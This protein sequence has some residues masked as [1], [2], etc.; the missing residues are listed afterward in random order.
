MELVW[1]AG[2]NIENKFIYSILSSS[3]HFNKS[4]DADN[5]DNMAITMILYCNYSP[6]RQGFLLARKVPNIYISLTKF[7]YEMDF[8]VP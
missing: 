4:L 7:C 5:L 3:K 6:I 8:S 1:L 2:N